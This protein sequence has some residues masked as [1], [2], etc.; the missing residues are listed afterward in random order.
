MDT[1]T[2]EELNKIWR[3]NWLW[4]LRDLTDIELQKRWIDKRISTPGW[5][6][7]EFMERY[8]D[9]LFL[10]DDGYKEHISYGHLTQDEYNCIKDFH[11]AL[12]AYVHQTEK[13][14]EDILNDL[15]WKQIVV[16][17]QKSLVK[18]RKLINDPDEKEIFLVKRSP[19][20]IGDFT[21]P[22]NPT[23]FRAILVRLNL[24]HHFPF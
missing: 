22:K 4:C 21:W 13:D 1:I 11:Q 8:F 12:A 17:G 14:P 20:Q 7:H 23:L 16:S 3:S 15:A 5:S 18:L 2:D 10:S 6:Y 24:Y 19:L 9:D